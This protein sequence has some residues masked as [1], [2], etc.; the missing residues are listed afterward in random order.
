MRRRGRSTISSDA[1]HLCT[2]SQSQVRPERAGAYAT[3]V[4]RLDQALAAGSTL[5]AAA[6]A[7][8]TWDRWLRRR[9][10]QELV[11]TISLVL[12]TVGAGSLWWASARGWSPASFRLFYLT[13]AIL[14]VP[15]LGAGTV[16]LLAGP[17]W[18][19]RVR[20]ALVLLSGLA[21]GVLLVAP[22]RVPVAGRELPEGKEVFGAFP[23]VLAAVGSAV[24][25]VVIF[26]GAVWS[27]WRVL[28]G[29]NPALGSAVRTVQLPRRLALGNAVI[30]AG[31]VILSLS[32][33]FAGRL[34][35][36]RAFSVTL[37]VGIA[38]L[39]AGFLIASTASA[40]RR[41]VV[42]TSATA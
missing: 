39:F 35:K 15:W 40:V 30:A 37:A 24:P 22:L 2:Y 19:D 31:T 38:V 18:G 9:R 11:W 6:F 34:G 4:H 13:G 23:R 29:R 42:T 33:T 10:P 28:R 17:R 3:E 8:A 1:R 7:L 41:R 27:A 12:F 16:Y 36:D 5:V 26:V 32:G 25:A 14:N 20:W 21:T